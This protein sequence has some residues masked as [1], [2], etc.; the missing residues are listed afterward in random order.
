MTDMLDH[1]ATTQKTLAEDR[2]RQ[3]RHADPRAG[4]GVRRASST[5]SRSASSPTSASATST[6]IRRDH[7]GAARPR[8][9]RPGH[10]LRRHLP[11]VLARGHR[12]AGRRRRSSTTWRSATTSCTASTTGP[13]IRRWRARTSS[14]TRPAR[15]DQWRHSHNYMHHTYTNIVGHGPRHRLRHPADE[16]G[17]AVD[18]R[19]TSATRST[20]SC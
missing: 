18:A 15:A 19:T 9:R 8:G 11:A 17:P 10:A 4:R 13:A 5:R 1:H 3:D 20:P 2:R 12:D 14:G 6:Y 16:R 7:Q